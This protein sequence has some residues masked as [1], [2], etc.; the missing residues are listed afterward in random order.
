MLVNIWRKKITYDFKESIVLVGY[1]IYGI[2]FRVPNRAI[3]MET[4]GK[5]Y[6]GFCVTLPTGDKHCYNT[7]TN[8]MDDFGMMFSLEYPRV[9]GAFTEYDIFVPDGWENRFDQIQEFLAYE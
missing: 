9:E 4:G 3:H 1:Q 8:I 7:L 6:T 5:T 2:L